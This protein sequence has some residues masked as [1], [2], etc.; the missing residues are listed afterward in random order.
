ML[1]LPRKKLLAHAQ[2]A[3]RLFPRA[4]VFFKYT[5]AACGTRVTFA[6]P[7]HL[8]ERGQCHQCGHEQDVTEGG[9]LL[10]LVPR[11]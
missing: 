1:N 8:F 7:N 11:G 9:Y 2:Q 5:C 3:L 10:N 6:E 4:K